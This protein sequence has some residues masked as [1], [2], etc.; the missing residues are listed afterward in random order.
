VLKD[1]FDDHLAVPPQ[2]GE[3]PEDMR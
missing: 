3:L 1:R 2:G